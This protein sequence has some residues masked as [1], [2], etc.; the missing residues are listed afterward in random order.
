MGSLGHK[1][2]LMFFYN[3]QGAEWGLQKG[4]VNSKIIVISSRLLGSLLRFPRISHTMTGEKDKV[5][6]IRAFRK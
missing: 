5:E 1:K 4:R 6:T 2:Y 3:H